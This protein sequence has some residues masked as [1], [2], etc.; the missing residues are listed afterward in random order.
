MQIMYAAGDLLWPWEHNFRQREWS[1]SIAVHSG[2]RSTTHANN[3]SFALWLYLIPWSAKLI[4]LFALSTTHMII[5]CVSSS[6]YGGSHPPPPTPPLDRL[7]NLR[8]EPLSSPK[9]TSHF[10]L[11]DSSHNFL[12][13]IPPSPSPVSIIHS[14]SDLPSLPSSTITILLG[15]HELLPDPILAYIL[16][17][18]TPHD[19]ILPLH[20]SFSP[21]RVHF[22]SL[23][24][25]LQAT[26]AAQ[27]L[28]LANFHLRHR[29]CGLCGSSTVPDQHGARRRCEKNVHNAEPH[30]V[31]HANVRN[32]PNC[33]GVWFPRIDPVAIMLVV[34]KDGKRAL[35]GRQR[36][37]TDGMYSC[38]AGFMEHAEGVD[39]TIRREVL[40]EAGIVV[41]KVR[42][43]GS[44]PWPYPYSLMLGC[45]ARAE[46]DEIIIDENEMQDVQWFDRDQVI[47]MRKI[48]EQRAG[49]NWEKTDEEKTK[50]VENF[51]PSA[52]SIAGELC[53]A[54]ADGDPRAWFGD[55]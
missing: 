39:D 2:V 37:Y 16:T 22:S 19:L 42:F 20:C 25:T 26:L 40:E 7:N 28:S 32:Q 27:S 48:G 14:H 34:S 1:Y 24:S 4:N 30:R 33:N 8:T 44:Q 29:F 21:L 52:S 10:V 11:L 36:R 13:S 18:P 41:G 3:K 46:T 54:F 43:F 23:P 47:E 9:S 49:K 17:I 50:P 38:L 6:T 35:L 12:F 55:E 53:A 31:T 51:V 15:A 45:F 5:P